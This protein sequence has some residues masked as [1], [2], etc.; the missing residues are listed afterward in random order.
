[1][2]S[3]RN[4]GVLFGNTVSRMVAGRTVGAD[5]VRVSGGSFTLEGSATVADT[6]K[7][8]P[9]TATHTVGLGHLTKAET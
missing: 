3:N 4:C 9:A 7:L 1:M 8:M 2:K 5:A 6:V